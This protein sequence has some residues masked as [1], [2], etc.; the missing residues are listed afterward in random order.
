VDSFVRG[1]EQ[2]IE[3]GYGAPEVVVEH[4]VVTGNEV[5]LRY[6][7]SYDWE[8]TGTL[9]VRHS[10]S[11]GNRI[12]NVRNHVNL[13]GGPAPGV[14]AIACSMVGTDGLDGVDGN[15]PGEPTGAWATRG[16]SDG[17]TMS[18]AACDGRTPGPSVCF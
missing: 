18:G 4:S 2:G 15:F 1:C 17:P 3:A 12:A 8:T 10:V 9:T 16:C 5:G 14:V 7:D 6:G 11:A 13:L